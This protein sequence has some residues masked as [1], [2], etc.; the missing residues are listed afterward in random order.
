MNLDDCEFPNV[1]N[2]EIYE[3][4]TQKLF[5]GNYFLLSEVSKN[6]HAETLVTT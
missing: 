6:L 4:F 1:W 5:L 3:N 2:A